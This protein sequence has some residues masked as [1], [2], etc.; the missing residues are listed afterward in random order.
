MRPSMALKFD[1]LLIIVNRTKVV[2]GFAEIG[3]KI[4]LNE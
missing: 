1:G 4:Y 3:N 2:T